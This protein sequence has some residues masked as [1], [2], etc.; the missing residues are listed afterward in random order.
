MASYSKLINFQAV[1][2]CVDLAISHNCIFPWLTKIGTKS[3]LTVIHHSFCTWR[4]TRCWFSQKY[5]NMTKNWILSTFYFNLLHPELGQTSDFQKAGKE[6]CLCSKIVAS[7]MS[8]PFQIC[9]KCDQIFTIEIIRESTLHLIC[10]WTICQLVII[11]IMNC[12]YFRSLSHALNMVLESPCLLLFEN[13]C[14]KS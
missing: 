9:N 10:N 4:K 14:H 12:I 5:G 13:N 11:M 1:L 2:I 7:W 6:V 8:P 3:L